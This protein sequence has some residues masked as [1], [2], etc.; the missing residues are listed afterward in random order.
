MSGQ[1]AP[2]SLMT[3]IRRADR[4]AEA[5]ISTGSAI[6]LRAAIIAHPIL[7]GET[8]N[9]EPEDISEA[10]GRIKDAAVAGTLNNLSRRDIKKGAYAFWDNSFEL[11][12]NSS[13]FAFY[14]H[15]MHESKSKALVSALVRSCLRH[16]QT[17]NKKFTT[18]L[19]ALKLIPEQHRTRWFNVVHEAGIFDGP[20]G[21][22]QIA[23]QTLSAGPGAVN[24]LNDIGLT[25]I[26]LNAKYSQA[27]FVEMCHLQVTMLDRKGYDALFAL[28]K[29]GDQIRFPGATREFISACLRPWAKKEPNADLKSFLMEELK[30]FFGDPRMHRAKWFGADASDIKIILRWLAQEQLQL[31]LDIVDKTAVD[32]M[33]SYRRAFWDAYFDARVITEAWVAFGPDALFEYGL[34]YP[35]RKQKGERE[36]GKL[37]GASRDQ[38][39]LLMKMGDHTIA[40]WSHNGRVWIW[41]EGQQGRK[42]PSLYQP[43]YSKEKCRGYENFQFWENHTGAPDYHWQYRVATQIRKLTGIR[44]NRRHWGLER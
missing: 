23:E 1:S 40:E 41:E 16:W 10:C 5:E 34:L 17:D 9:F 33:W 12:Q 31:F 26:L 42:P 30:A 11:W 20:V 37:S 19:E 43:T 24:L 7:Q 25:P 6:S 36:F 21:I 18:F 38:S 22:S 4:L 8:D 29:D 13:V 14:A 35:D 44:M 27:V 2:T 28:F 32:R 3:A 15:R 39:V